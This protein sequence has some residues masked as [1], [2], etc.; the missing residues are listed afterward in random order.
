MHL[1]REAEAGLRESL[2]SGKVTLVLGA[3]QVGKTTV[4][5]GVLKGKHARLL[6]FDQVFTSHDPCS[7]ALCALRSSRRYRMG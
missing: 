4:V 6:N 2:A 5:E 7:A 1:A 3:R